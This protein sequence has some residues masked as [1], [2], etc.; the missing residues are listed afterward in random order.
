MELSESV[1]WQGRQVAWGRAGSGPAVVFCHGTPFSS[2]LWRPF[3]ET[4]AG[5]FTVYL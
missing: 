5:D 2:L 3:A 4:L 1:D